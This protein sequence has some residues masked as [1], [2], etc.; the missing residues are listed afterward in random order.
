MCSFRKG[1][2]SVIGGGCQ[3]PLAC[4]A[5]LLKNKQL[6]IIAMIGDPYCEMPMIKGN[7]E[8]RIEDAQKLGK[9]LAEE[10]LLIGG[11]DILRK[12]YT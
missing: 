8:G 11:R 3:V 1:F 5:K 2:L 9:E 12:V 7:K 4:H 6:K 10:L